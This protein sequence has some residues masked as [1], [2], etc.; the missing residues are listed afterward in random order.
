MVLQGVVKKGLVLLGVIDMVRG[1]TDSFNYTDWNIH[2]GVTTGSGTTY[3]GN[4]RQW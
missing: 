4:Y 2:G 1:T 3:N